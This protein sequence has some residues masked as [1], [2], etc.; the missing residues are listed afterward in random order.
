MS[1]TLKL[2]KKTQTWQADAA[3]TPMTKPMVVETTA[4]PARSARLLERS[5]NRDNLTLPPHSLGRRESARLYYA[6]TCE[7]QRYQKDRPILQDNGM[8]MAPDFNF[9]RSDN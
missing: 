3:T 4:P 2:F 1:A 5:E 7:A 8:E 9:V 6:S